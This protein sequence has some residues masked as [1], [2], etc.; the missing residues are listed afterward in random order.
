MHTKFKV[1]PHSQKKEPNC[2]S[3]KV[4][5]LFNKQ[6]FIFAKISKNAEVFFVEKSKQDINGF[7]YILLTINLDV[8]SKACL[9]VI[10]SRTKC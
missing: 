4:L 8:C 6:I 3:S 1:R 7:E 9:V 5:N 2:K 10:V